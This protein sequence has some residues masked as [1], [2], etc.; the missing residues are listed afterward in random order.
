MLAYLSYKEIHYYLGRLPCASFQEFI[1]P[2]NTTAQILL[3]HYI[4]LLVL[5][6]PINSCEW[7]GRNLGRFNRD[8]VFKLNSILEHVLEDMRQY[9]QWPAVATGSIPGILAYL[10]RF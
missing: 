3:T 5:M 8:T 7:A 2:S 1:S 4:A 9:L 10:K 6:A